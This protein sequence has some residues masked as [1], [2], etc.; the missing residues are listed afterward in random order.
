ML[1]F[2]VPFSAK[3][4]TPSLV[5]LRGH[6]KNFWQPTLTFSCG[7]PPPSLPP[8][9]IQPVKCTCEYIF[10]LSS[11]QAAISIVYFP[12][13]PHWRRKRGCLAVRTV[14]ISFYRHT[15][16]QT[17]NCWRPQKWYKTQGRAGAEH[18]LGQFDRK[19]LHHCHSP[20]WFY[21]R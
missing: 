20:T 6:N 14:G 2:L 16:L 8:E 1:Q 13:T 5:P 19:A 9:I 12:G 18:I 10:L 4:T 21:R 3:R 15:W 17:F 11:F 7:R